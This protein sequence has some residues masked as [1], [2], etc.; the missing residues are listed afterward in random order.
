MT[1][2][3]TSSRYHS[4]PLHQVTCRKSRNTASNTPHPAWTPIHLGQRS[5][6][7]SHKALS[8]TVFELWRRSCW[9]HDMS[10]GRASDPCTQTQTST[11]LKHGSST[12]LHA[13][14]ST[15]GTVR[16]DPALSTM[17]SFEWRLY[18]CHWM[19]TIG[20]TCSIG[21][22]GVKANSQNWELQG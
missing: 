5:Q 19:K 9:L 14:N 16:F 18:H 13:N 11:T 15:I 12:P 10:L 6:I 7:T 17:V 2:S 4:R 22:L 1:V 21:P 20:R 3:S 8:S